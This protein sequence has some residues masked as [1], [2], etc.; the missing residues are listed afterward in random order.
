MTLEM[1]ITPKIAKNLKFRRSSQNISVKLH[2]H[3][4]LTTQRDSE[5]QNFEPKISAKPM[6]MYIYKIHAR[7]KNVLS[8]GVQLKKVVF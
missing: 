8:E 1:E 7:I 2:T 6:H 5:I 4:F 3:I